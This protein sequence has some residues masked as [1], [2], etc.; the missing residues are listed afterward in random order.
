M[1]IQI[2]FPGLV[3]LEVETLPGM[4]IMG[5]ELVSLYFVTDAYVR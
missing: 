4:L 3:V 5:N 2:G 1:S